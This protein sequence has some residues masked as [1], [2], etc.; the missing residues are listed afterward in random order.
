MSNHIISSHVQRRLHESLP[1]FILNCFFPRR[2][3]E[4]PTLPG[5][6]KARDAITVST[7]F[8]LSFKDRLR[9]IFCGSVAITTV[10]A[11]RE[12]PGMV[13]SNSTLHFLPPLHS[14]REQPQHQPPPGAAQ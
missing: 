5:D 14:F 6:M 9:A 13:S 4:I 1:R 12:K 7:I 2:E 8:P 3:P 11:C 10:T